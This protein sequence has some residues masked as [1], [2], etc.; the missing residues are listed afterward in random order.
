MTTLLDKS[1]PVPEI[2]D[3]HLLKLTPKAHAYR[4]KSLNENHPYKSG[5]GG[6]EVGN[7]KSGS[8]EKNYASG[9]N[10]NHK[11]WENQSILKS[12]GSSHEHRLLTGSKKL[13]ITRCLSI[14]PFPQAENLSLGSWYQPNR[15]STLTE[16]PQ[17]PDHSSAV[18]SAWV[19]TF[20]P[21]HFQEV[22]Q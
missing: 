11:L 10:R 15:E 8:I 22:I 13:K 5:I 7:Q 21:I 16:Y 17:P 6:R 14:W 4:G 18:K 2:K 9:V 20:T 19:L 1:T 3:F 12:K